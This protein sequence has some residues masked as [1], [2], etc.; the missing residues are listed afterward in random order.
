[1]ICND[2]EEYVSALCDGETVPQEAAHHIGACTACQARL[3]DYLAMG[4]ELRRV[5]SLEC[6]EPTPELHL[7]PKQRSKPSLWQKGWETMRIPKFAF[8][9]LVIAVL[10]LAS[11]LAVVKVGA[12][13]AGSVLKLTYA[14]P[15]LKPGDCYLD[16][17]RKSDACG[18]FTRVNQTLVGLNF[19]SLA[20]DGDRVQLGIRAK[21]I[22]STR[23]NRLGSPEL[24]KEQQVQYS[25]EVGQTLNLDVENLGVIAVTGEWTDHVPSLIGESQ[26]DPRPDELRFASPLLLRDKQVVGDMEG[27]TSTV[28]KPEEAA[29]IYLPG[30]GSFII[31][32]VH[33]QGGREASV[34]M[35]RISF[36]EDGHNYTFITGTPISREKHLWVLHQPGFKPEPPQPS[37]VKFQSSLTLRETSPGVWVSPL[38]SHD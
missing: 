2:A 1:M 4:V 8:A 33:I 13:S 21:A 29:W 19:Q 25:F 24:D 9:L 30:E 28:D 16:T 23:P 18:F 6:S 3:R 31:S 22:P 17:L 34:N 36:D 14:I 11:S 27:A 26:L 5:A 15:G 7:E 20:R 12:R 10:A 38:T 37:D 35:N 32:A